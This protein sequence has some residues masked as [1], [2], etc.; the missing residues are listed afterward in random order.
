V[1]RNPSKFVIAR[2]IEIDES[3]VAISSKTGSYEGVD[4]STTACRVGVKPET[5]RSRRGRDLGQARNPELRLPYLSQGDPMNRT[6]TF[7]RALLILSLLVFTVALI[8]PPVPAHGAE[9][10]AFLI[11]LKTSLKKDD[12]Q[13]CV[14]YNVI[15]AALE[16]GY[17]VKVLVDADAINTFKVGWFG[18][19][20]IEK[21]NIPERLRKELAEQLSVPLSEVPGTYGEFLD[22]LHEKG[23]EFYINTG[24]LI[25][26]KI[27]TPGDPLKKVSA[28]FFTPV[29]LKEMVRMRA[30]ADHY[31]VY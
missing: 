2:N 25:V 30:D 23:A 14:A 13:I 7:T 1:S 26:S 5:L 27:G 18:K 9:P 15:W 29:T 31:I 28:K 10:E 19:D 17:K 6:I 3:D 20:D 24:F 11:H 12:A 16:E 8:A 21:Y 22:M 4:L